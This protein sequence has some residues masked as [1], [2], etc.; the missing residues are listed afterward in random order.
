MVSDDP[1]AVTDHAPFFSDLPTA[2]LK[3][4]RCNVAVVFNL[5]ATLD[6]QSVLGC[7][8]VACSLRV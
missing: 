8:V 1:V 4:A 2:C 3:R 5:V 7:G 6:A